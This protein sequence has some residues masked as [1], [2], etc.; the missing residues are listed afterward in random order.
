M[1]KQQR[2][3]PSDCADD[4]SCRR[5][6]DQGESDAGAHSHDSHAYRL[7]DSRAGAHSHDAHGHDAHGHDAHSHDAHGHDAHSHDHGHRPGHVHA[8]GHSHDAANLSG[9]KIFWVTVLNVTI[10]LAELAG[11]L[12]SGSLALLSDSMHNFSDSVAIVMSYLANQIARRPKNARKTFGYQ[13]AEILAAFVNAAVLLAISLFLIVE[14]VRRW[15]QPETI[16]GTLM[17]VVAI[18]GLAANLFS[19][20][21]LEKDSHHNLNI[22]SSYLHLLGDTVSS[23]GVVLGGLAIRFWGVLWLDPLITIL[24]SLYIGKETWGILR[25]TVDILMQGSADLDYPSIV[26]DIEAIDRVRNIHHIHSWM[27]NDRTIH[28]EAHLDLDDMP[29]HDVQLIYGQVEELLAERYGIS[30]VTLQAEV[31]KCANK[32]VF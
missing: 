31:D 11:G 26:Q 10:T 3:S 28:F 5:I 21:L 15:R 6:H 1:N 17:M 19:V 27:I 16:N 12:I 20:Y 24:I 30:H 18:I 9:R 22:K 13:R 23:V 25:K 4:D 7:T 2:K 29:L 14:A 8:H 32:N